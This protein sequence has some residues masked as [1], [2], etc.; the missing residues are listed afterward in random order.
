MI[1]PAAASGA[2]ILSPSES[3][4]PSSTAL[5][6]LGRSTQRDKNKFTST[7][8]ARPWGAGNAEIQPRQVEWV[9]DS[10]VGDVELQAGQVSSETQSVA[11]RAR[12]CSGG[13]ASSATQSGSHGS[14]LLARPVGY[15]LDN[16]ANH[17]RSVVQRKPIR[18]AVRRSAAHGR[19]GRTTTNARLSPRSQCAGADALEGRATLAQ[20]QHQQDG[21]GR[22][23]DKSRRQDCSA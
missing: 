14:L 7:I 15:H 20:D 12:G 10:P 4:G 18:V 17:R 1:R 23:R 13:R 16:I 11:A 9:R 19:R 6:N 22:V 3:T 8:S 5:T 21:I 2:C